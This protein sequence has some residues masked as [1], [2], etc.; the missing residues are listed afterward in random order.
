MAVQDCDDLSNIIA[1]WILSWDDDLAKEIVRLSTQKR[2]SLV[3]AGKLKSEDAVEEATWRSAHELELKANSADIELRAIVQAKILTWE[4][5][6]AEAYVALAE[7]ITKSGWSMSQWINLLNKLRSAKV[8][9]LQ[10]IAKLW[11]WAYK[12]YPAKAK[13]EME[14]A[15]ASTISA[16][17]SIR[18]YSD[19]MSWEVSDLKKQLKDGKITQEQYE[20]QMKWLHKKVMD[21]INAWENPKDFVPIDKEWDTI[22]RMYSTEN[23]D[24]DAIT[25]VL[26][27]RWKAWSQYVMARELLADWMVDDE[28]LKAFESLFEM[29]NLVGELTIDDIAKFWKWDL[30]KLLAL[31][32]TNTEQLYKDWMLREA[33]RA[34]L[35]EVT[36]WMKVSKE[37]IAKATSIMNTI[38]FAEQWASFADIATADAAAR[39]ARKRWFKV[40][41]WKT[42]LNSLKSFL[43][44][45]EDKMFDWPIVIDWIEMTAKDIIQI[46]YDITWDENILKLIRIGFYSDETILSIATSKLFNDSDDAAKKILKLFSKAWDWNTIANT[47]N[48]ALKAITWEEI[49][50]WA[51]IGFFNFR[52]NLYLKDELD[53]A[54]AEFYDKLADRNKMKVDSS[55]IEDITLDTDDADK[56]ADKLRKFKWGYIIVNDARYKTNKAFNDAL[57]KVNSEIKNEEDKITCIFPRWWMSSSFVMENWQLYFKTTNAKIFDNVAWTISIQSMWKSRPTREIIA[58]AFEAKTGKNG[59]RLRY[60]ASYTKG[61]VDNQGRQISDQQVERFSE[62]EIRDENW[63]LLTMY[64]WT[65]SEFDIFDYSK[66]WKGKWLNEGP[67]FYFSADPYKAVGYWGKQI[68]VYLDIKNPFH[69]DWKNKSKLYIDDIRAVARDLLNSN[70]MTQNG[71]DEMMSY[72]DNYAQFIKRDEDWREYIDSSVTWFILEIWHRY[73]RNAVW[74]TDGLASWEWW[75]ESFSRISWYDW[76]INHYSGDRIYTAVAFSPEQIKYVNN[77]LPTSS[78][79]MKFQFN[80][81]WYSTSISDWDSLKSLLDWGVDDEDV[82]KYF[83]DFVYNSLDRTTL[84]WLVDEFTMMPDLAKFD[85]LSFEE[86][87]EIINRLLIWNSVFEAEDE[88]FKIRNITKRHSKSEKLYDDSWDTAKKLI[89]RISLWWAFADMEWNTT[90]DY[91]IRKF[92]DSWFMPYEAWI[93]TNV[94]WDVI[95]SVM[96]TGAYNGTN[97]SFYKRM[98]KKWWK[99]Y[100]HNHPNW[101]FFSVPDVDAFRDMMQHWV[102]SVWLILPWWVKLEFPLNKKTINL[103]EKYQQKSLPVSRAG[104]PS[105][106]EN[107]I[108]SAYLLSYEL[109]IVDKQEWWMFDWTIKKIKWSELTKADYDNITFDVEAALDDTRQQFIDALTPEWASNPVWQKRLDDY[110]S[111]QDVAATDAMKAQMFTKDRT[112]QEIADAYWVSVEFVKWTHMIAWVEAYWAYWDGIIYFT[113]MVKESTA[114]HELFHAIFDMH[115]GKEQHDKLLKQWSK[116]FNVSEDEMEEIMADSFAHWFNTWEFIYWDELIKA[117]KKKKP[118]KAEKSFINK[119]LEV[120][121]DLKKWLWLMDDHRAEVKQM[122]DDM[123]NMKYLPDAWKAVEATEAMIKYNDDLEK[124]AIKYYWQLLWD[125]QEDLSPEY[126]E[127]IRTKLSEKTWIDFKSFDQIQDKALLWQ[128]VDEAFVVDKLVSG[129]Y[130]KEIVDVDNLINWI[131]KLT[132]KELEDAIFKDLWVLS[133]WWKVVGRDTIDAIRNA[134]ID[135]KTAWNAVDSLIAKG[136]LTAYIHWTEAQNVSM[137]DIRTIFQNWTFAQKYKEMFFPNQKLTAKE[138]QEIIKQI[139]DNIFDTLSIQFAENLV[140]AWYELP[141]INIKTF[142]Y[143]Y[144][145]WKL[146]LN[147][148]F[149]EAFLYKNN[150]PFSS[151]W[152]KWIVDSLMP[153]EL[154][155]N[156]N[157]SKYSYWLGQKP[158]IWEKAVFKEVDNRFVMDSYSALAWIELAAKWWIPE[159]EERKILEEILTKY[160][161]EVIKWV[162]DWTL[163]FKWAQELKQEV[164]YALDMFEQDILLPKYGIFLSPQEKQWLIGM[165]YDLPI[166]VKWQNITNVTKQLNDI[167]QKLLNKYDNTLWSIAEN[168]DIN[169]AILKWIKSEDERIQKKIDARRDMLAERWWVIREVN[170]QYLVYN[171]KQALEYALED[172]PPSINWLEWLRVLWKEWIDKL[173]NQQAYALL[174]YIE[175]AKSLDATA[176]YAIE[177]MYKQN[178]MLLQYNFFEAYRVWDQWIPKALEW[179]SLNFDK[180]LSRLENTAK[181]DETSKKNIFEWVINKFRKQW[182]VTNDDLDDII[183]KWI[184]EAYAT[185]KQSH[186]S[187]KEIKKAVNKMKNIY[188]KA[189]AP[190]TY[191]RDIPSWGTVDWVEFRNIK[192]KVRE[193]MKQ[194]YNQAM[195]DLKSVW[196]TN[197]D[198]IQDTIYL[199]LPTWQKMSLRDASTLDVDSWKKWIFNDE[200]VYVAWADELWAAWKKTVEEQKEFRKAMVNE[201]DST[202]QTILNQS[203]F[204]SESER[205]LQGSIMS[206]VRAML[207]QW[208]LT[209]LIV[210]ALDAVSWL[211]EEAA[212]W[213]KDYLIW[214]KWNISFWKWKSSQIIERNE[215]VKKAYAQYYAMDLSKLNKVTPWT[216]AEDLALRLAR[217][218]KNLERLLGSADWVTWCTTSNQLNRAFFHIGEVVMNVDSVKWIFWLLSAVE[219]NQILKLFKFAK[220]DLRKQAEVF[221]RKGKGNFTES[222]WWYRDYAEDI[223]WITRD[224]FNEIFWTSFNEDDFKKILQWLTGFSLVWWVTKPIMKALNFLSWTNF[225]FRAAMSYPWQLLTIPLQSTAYFLKQIWLERA[226]DIDSLSDIDEVRVHYWILD[227][228]YNEINWFNKKYRVSPDDVRVDSYY[229]RYWIP[230]VE[231]IYKT[232]SIESSDD[233]INMYAKINNQAAS[234]ISS[235]NKW[236]RQLDPYKDNANNIIDWLFARNFKNIAFQKAI[237][238]NDFM[239]FSSAKEFLAFMEDPTVWGSVK[240]K[241]LDRV[242][243]YS[244]RN[245]RNILWLGFWWIDRAVWWSGFGNIMY[246]LMQMFNF[247]WS[248]WQNIFKQAWAAIKT[249]LKIVKANPWLSREWRDAVGRYIATQPEFMNFVWALFNDLKRSWRLQRFQDNWRWPDNEDM[250][251]TTEFWDVFDTYSALD[252]IDYLTESLSLTSQ[253]FQWIQSFWPARPILEWVESAYKSYMDPTIY[254]DTFWIWAFFNALWKNFWRQWKPHNWIAKAL[255]ALTTDWPEAFWTYVQNEWYKLSFG[256]VRYMVNE[257]SNSY[258]YTFEMTWQQWW[259]PSIIMWEWKQGSDKN[260]SYEIDNT[261]TWETIKQLFSSWNSWDDRLTYAWNL[262]KAFVNWSQFFSLWKNAWKAR[263]RNAPSYYTADDLADVLQNTE[264][265]L[266]FYQKWIVT[267]KTK[268]EAEIFFDTILENSKFRPWSS[269]FT[270]SLINYEDYWHMNGK[271]KWNEADAEME[272]WLDHMKHVTDDHWVIRKNWSEETIDPS[273][274]KLINAVRSWAYNETYTTNLI[275]NYAKTWLDNHSSDPNYQL[276]LKLLWQWQAHKLI[277]STQDDIIKAWNAGKKW[278]DNKWTETEFKNAWLRRDM[279]L[280][281]WNTPL[282]WDTETF[283]DKLQV[284]DEDSATVAAL[285]IIQSQAK[286]WDRKIIDRFFNVKENDDWTKSVTLR[287]QYESTLTQIWAVAK[288]IDDWNLERAISESSILTNMYK[289]QDPSGAVTAT[290]IDSVVN[291]IYDTDSFSPEQKQEAIIAL[292]HHNKEFIQ[293]N[294]EKLRELLWDEYDTYA[295][296]MNQMLYQWD[297]ALLSTLESMQT[298]WK[299]SSWTAKKTKA[300]SSELKKLAASLGNEWW[301][302]G[303]W[304]V[305]STK[306]WVPV[307]IKWADLVKELWLKGYTPNSVSLSVKAYKP[308]IDLSVA[309]DV[310]R[311]VKWPK[312]Q[313]ISNKKQ[314]SKLEDKVTKAIE[315]ES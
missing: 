155:F 96:G 282:P 130:D 80:P 159:N 35:V 84:K 205:A 281:M 79:N 158:H 68:E 85:K 42:F 171:A 229:N 254:K 32:F 228:A 70:K 71:Y 114:P 194:Q 297:W 177:L 121:K 246:W 164:W 31:A 265:W 113:D 45:E 149:V 230:D 21:R 3:R 253:L 240:Q 202:L 175:A 248:W 285:Q 304:T 116:L 16:N 232:T 236:I 111:Q 227:W 219:Q 184:K 50:E 144:L 198:W 129:R 64:H 251:V 267:P 30:D 231:W 148:K 47:R 242:A 132:D 209:N 309:K 136:K 57:N 226:L 150:I 220:W 269:N 48:I 25:E 101:S 222:L 217:Y 185:Y 266:E 273:W 292:F 200:S 237:R 72:L 260:F 87:Y 294:P 59:D 211:N 115:V 13:K 176:W 225:I 135:Y 283:F 63:Y 243:A 299:G 44:K 141:L 210:D 215:L 275:Y 314:L 207:R 37:N 110:A 61:W 22:K 69:L 178:P 257:D 223:S 245:F 143:D 99:K 256:S 104:D 271:E 97:S 142:M 157:F 65:D 51:K 91:F 213:I 170:W 38:G 192:S 306:S 182:Y 258:G 8:T 154:N 75:L 172:L 180:L 29:D 238:Q 195:E 167:K 28:L 138:E 74:V 152:L 93:Y 249:W 188:K 15:I 189:F 307:V 284:L 147:N 174:R 203:Q 39:A 127:R 14:E 55:D 52:K 118:N 199:T 92:T 312:T 49:K 6:N 286:E 241:L 128:K 89:D 23:V 187:P 83:Y 134:Y 156:Y 131:E 208:N 169:E 166:W 34:K 133:K 58:K 183:D 20:E 56:I 82:P 95:G 94:N 19:F 308:K 4:I 305:W 276:Y 190:Y 165:K 120:F 126:I 303:T 5:W 90:L 62:S 151:D 191:L 280:S 10:D 252:F 18:K 145:N 108:Y 88:L 112:V 298:S 279:L 181:L 162:K 2:D 264:A 119:V 268:E 103:I 272:L 125:Y 287:R 46:I 1:I 233:Y 27:A 224:E 146:D 244:G 186:M 262:W 102:D 206:D 76:F 214:W 53:S 179:N 137:E 313:Q 43:R 9:D 161:N 67:G 100:Y 247:R 201:Y 221:I 140:S 302:R 234:S 289:N 311:K 86:Q 315:A 250:Y 235:T 160:V 54:K 124:A 41:D 98:A 78:K 106:F 278:V 204:I 255:W 139:N 239:Q 196:I 117:A 300:T 77:R 293:K 291:R 60:Q 197:T 218:F 26:E 290:L 270:K 123:V 274:N 163:D 107:S 66:I 33:Y 193:A 24:S 288:A 216:K 11:W 153:S 212:R 173:S 7:Q 12:N 40:K 17:Y 259:I 277:E 168:N 296:Y 261:E 301:A 105:L 122:F 310:N 263:N 73:R 295:N 109:W 81:R 36:S